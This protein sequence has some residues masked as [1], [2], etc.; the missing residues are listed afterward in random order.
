MAESPSSIVPEIAMNRYR[1]FLFLA[2]A[3]AAGF[4]HADPAERMEYPKTRRVDHVDTYF[5]VKVP[6]PYRWLE[7]DVRHDK[8]VADWVAAENKV[9]TRY[10]ESIPE[11]EAIRRR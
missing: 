6:D 11:R 5:G 1:C 4:A 7:A 8:A 10:L 3:V 9:T 2:A